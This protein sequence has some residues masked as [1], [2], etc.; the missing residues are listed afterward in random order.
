MQMF[1]Y[2]GRE[3][4]VPESSAAATKRAQDKRGWARGW[5]GGGRRERVGKHLGLIYRVKVIFGD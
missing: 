4:R 1:L 5:R 2:V 3:E